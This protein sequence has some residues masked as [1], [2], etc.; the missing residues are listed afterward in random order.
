MSFL[1][2]PRYLAVL[3]TDGDWYCRDTLRNRNQNR[4]LS[5]SQAQIGARQAN[6]RVISDEDL[7]LLARE[8][9]TGPAISPADLADQL[10]E[11][12]EFIAELLA[13]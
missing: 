8:R 7:E 2:S 3:D 5:E 6:D 1:P 13:R 10:L 11:A 12:R 9:Y 4:F